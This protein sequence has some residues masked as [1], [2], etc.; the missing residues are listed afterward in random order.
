V[1]IA[2]T[3][4]AFVQA[5]GLFRD[6]NSTSEIFSSLQLNMSVEQ[7]TQVTKRLSRE[8]SGIFVERKQGIERRGALRQKNVY[9][10]KNHEFIPRFFKSPTF[11]SHCRDFIW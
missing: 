9:T 5:I 11:C 8:P 3:C 1:Y 4:A 2:P 6:T 7:G 10:V